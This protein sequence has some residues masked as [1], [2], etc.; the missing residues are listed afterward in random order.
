MLFRPLS[1]SS[2]LPWPPQVLIFIL[3]KPE[4]IHLNC[5]PGYDY[6]WSQSQKFLRTEWNMQ[7]SRF[8]NQFPQKT[9]QQNPHSKCAWRKGILWSQTIRAVCIPFC[10]HH[11]LSSVTLCAL[12]SPMLKHKTVASHMSIAHI[13]PKQMSLPNWRLIRAGAAFYGFSGNFY[14]NGLKHL[15][16]HQIQVPWFLSQFYWGNTWIFPETFSPH[17]WLENE[18]SQ[19]LKE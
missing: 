18:I 1:S 6:L 2:L 14:K 5:F 19:G 13:L 12:L 4:Q 16:L 15:K 7:G 3:P 17:Y 10:S 9:Q 11:P 8:Q